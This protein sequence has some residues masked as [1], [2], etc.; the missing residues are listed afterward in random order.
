MKIRKRVNRFSDKG[1]NKTEKIYILKG[2]EGGG[3][4]WEHSR[5]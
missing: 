4:T 2:D 1:L 3:N 5:N